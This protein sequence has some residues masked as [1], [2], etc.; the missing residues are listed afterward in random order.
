LI[1]TEYQK[2][3][4]GHFISEVKL[5]RQVKYAGGT[6]AVPGDVKY[7]GGTPAVPGDVKYAG[8][9]PAVPGG[10]FAVIVIK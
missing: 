3:I 2:W 5:E 6:P 1:L 8:G 7:A 10:C 9:T 4:K